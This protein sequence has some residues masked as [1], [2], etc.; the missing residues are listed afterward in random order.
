MRDS[1]ISD[2]LGSMR[3]FQQQWKDART[4]RRGKTQRWYVE[5]RDHHDV[6]RKVG[7]FHDKAQTAMLGKRLEALVGLR[8][9]GEEPSPNLVRWACELPP[10]LQQRILE[11]DLVDAKYVVAAKPI[12]DH[13]KD[14]AVSLKAK[15]TGQAQ[16]DLVTGRV[17][18]ILAACQFMQVRDIDATRVEQHLLERRQDKARS[19]SAQASN[20]NLAAIK[21]FCRWM[22]AE[23]RME[24]S[25]VARIRPVN[26]SVDRRRERRALS[27]AAAGKLLRAAEIGPTRFGISGVDRALL[28]RVALETGLRRGELESLT[29][30]SFDCGDL[31]TVTVNASSSKRRRLDVLPI[32]RELADLL[33]VHLVGCGPEDRALRV[34]SKQAAAKM[35]RGDLRAAGIPIQDEHGRVVDFHALRHTAITRWVEAGLNPKVTQQLARHSVISLTMDRYAHI[36]TQTLRDGIDG[37]PRIQ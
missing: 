21:Q 8:V 16:I 12:L 35:I 30:A 17:K 4:G 36:E 20:H 18:R 31:P 3:V 27:A 9:L 25:P 13:L 1:R 11:L 5:L 6:A 28:Y 15:G 14:F 10:K 33:A 22:V 2:R 23:E 32:R 7:G 19:L 29:A 37:M 24:R 26:V 34:P